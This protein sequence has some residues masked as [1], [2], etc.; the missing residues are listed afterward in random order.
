ML[1]RFHR[2]QREL[3]TR[4]R[5]VSETK[6]LDD[7][8]GPFSLPAPLFY[9]W[10]FWPYGI[11][12]AEGGM[13]MREI[14]T[15]WQIGVLA[16][17]PCTFL[18]QNG[19]FSAFSQYKNKER[20]LK[21]LDVKWHIPSTCLD[22]FQKWFSIGIYSINRASEWLCLEMQETSQNGRNVHGFQVRTPIC[23]IVPVSRAYMYGGIEILNPPA[24]AILY[25]PPSF[26]H[27]WGCIRC[28]PPKQTACKKRVGE[29]G[30]RGSQ[31]V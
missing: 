8:W 9:C 26:T 18:V 6:F 5:P 28:G 15:M 29:A 31:G 7:F 23:H 16:G 19:S 4:N 13:Y 10:I 17:K 11:F 24:A 25:P 14:G 22:A 3:C 1:C 2:S 12:R 27:S 30:S 21:G 20:L